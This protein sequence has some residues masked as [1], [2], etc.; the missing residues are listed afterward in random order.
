MQAVIVEGKYDVMRVKSVVDATVISTNGFRLF[1]DEE[2]KN[3]L[4][5]LAQTVGVIILTDSDSAGMVIRNHLLSFLPA[6]KVKNAYVPPIKGKEKRKSVPSKE[7]LLGVEGTDGDLIR[8]ALK[9]AGG[10]FEGEDRQNNQRHLSK[11]DLAELGLSGAPDSAQKRQALYRKLHLP[12]YLSANRL[13]DYLN[14]A[15][16]DEEWEQLKKEL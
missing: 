7:G 12:A 2:K 14:T 6:E 1:H 16:S 10:I 9:E 4:R 3:M 15:L 13:L 11:S 8:Q 5:T